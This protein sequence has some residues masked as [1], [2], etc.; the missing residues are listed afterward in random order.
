MHKTPKLHLL[1]SGHIKLKEEETKL[2]TQVVEPLQYKV[3]LVFNVSKQQAAKNT[4]DIMNYTYFPQILWV[5][6]VHDRLHH[7]I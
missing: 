4:I 7:M 3:A 5:S 2:F 1:T 6:Y